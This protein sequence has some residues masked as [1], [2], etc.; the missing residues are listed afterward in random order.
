V[1]HASVFS[2]A[3]LGYYAFLLCI[4]VLG[5]G[6]RTRFRWL[7]TLISLVVMATL[8]AAFFDPNPA[9]GWY[10]QGQLACRPP[11]AHAAVKRIE[12]TRHFGG[13]RLTDQELASFIAGC[14]SD[15]R[16]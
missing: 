5:I 13:T 3:Q 4:V 2:G 11:V 1:N 16:A 10:T 6:L 8:V 14:R 7:T 9:S 15:P 12:R